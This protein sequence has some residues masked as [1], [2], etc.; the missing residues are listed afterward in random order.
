MLSRSLAT[1]AA[2][3][4]LATL[5]TACAASAPKPYSGSGGMAAYSITPEVYLH[6]YQHGF[7]G[8]DAMGWDANLQLAWSR[9]GA[10][11]TCGVSYAADKLLAQLIA[12]YGHS[13]TVHGMVGIDFHHLQSKG[14][15]GFCSETRVA[16]LR[17]LLPE[18]AQGRFVKR[19]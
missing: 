9:I 4:L 3:V 13:E 17:L 18:F 2:P 14:V 11:K 16:E 10:A 12:N 8:R 1:A 15:S 7:T 19:Y 6:H 5:L